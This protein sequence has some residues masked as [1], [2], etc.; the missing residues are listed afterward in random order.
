MDVDHGGQCS[1]FR[2]RLD[3]VSDGC[4]DS[5]S[6]HHLG[7]FKLNYSLWTNLWIVRMRSIRACLRVV[8]CQ[9]VHRQAGDI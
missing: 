8:A 4:N 1:G 7:K 9:V 5:Q 6:T 3:A 2:G